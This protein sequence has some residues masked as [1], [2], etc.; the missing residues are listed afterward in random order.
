MVFYHK[1]WCFTTSDGV[2][3][4]AMVF[5][6][7]RRCFIT[8]GQSL[9]FRQNN[10]GRRHA[11][12][13][14]LRCDAGLMKNKRR[15]AKSEKSECERREHRVLGE[16]N[17]RRLIRSDTHAVLFHLIFKVSICLIQRCFSRESLGRR[18]ALRAPMLRVLRPGSR[19]RTARGA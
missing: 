13:A 4:Q 12:K 3:P 14:S 11:F 17:S 6:H 9:S 8:N 16:G 5:Y 18:H 19:V 7:K 2:L 15:I 10:W 1:R